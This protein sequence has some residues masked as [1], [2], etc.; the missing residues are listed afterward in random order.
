MGMWREGE[1]EGKRERGKSK[2]VRRKRVKAREGGGGK[3]PLL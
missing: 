3:Q 1:Q 2:R